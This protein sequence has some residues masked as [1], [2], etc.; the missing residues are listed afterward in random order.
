MKQS[1]VILILIFSVLF[2]LGFVGYNLWRETQ[3]LQDFSW[4]AFFAN[5]PYQTAYFWLGI[6][7]ALL[8]MVGR[9]LGYMARIKTLTEDSLSWRGA[10]RSIMVW[11]FSSAISPGVVGGSGVAMFILKR[12]GIKLGRATAI[13]FVTALLDNLFYLLCVPL[14]LYFLPHGEVFPNYFS[15]DILGFTLDIKALFWFGYIVIA[16]ITLVL[17]LSLSV[18]PTLVLRFLSLLFQLSWLK[19]WK[20][21]ALQMGEDLITAASDIRDFSVFLWFKAFALTI[22]SWV[23]RYLVVNALFFAFFPSMDFMAHSTLF[24]LQLV[25]WVL[26]LISPTPGGSGVAELVFHTFFAP[27]LPSR[28]LGSLLGVLWRLISY[29]PYLIIGAVI[30]PKWLAEKPKVVEK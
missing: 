16:S 22:L 26:L 17:L 29:Y 5:I 2:S 4:Q 30:L 27:F 3:S 15:K 28:L 10:F 14:F 21:D 13:V 1:K 8:G 11:E 9:D 25:V 23:S 12:E 19:K 18:F 7:L 6:L 20:A 24:A